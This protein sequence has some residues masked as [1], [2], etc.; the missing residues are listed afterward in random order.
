MHH[1]LGF[2]V[3][4]ACL[5]A[6]MG[7]SQPRSSD[8]TGAKTGTVTTPPPPVAAGHSHPSEGPHHGDLI[9]LGNEEFHAEMVH[10]E[11]SVTIYLLDAAAKVAVPIEASDLVINL[12]H[13]GNPEQF[14]LSASPDT[15]D[16]TGKSSR[17]VSTDA[18]LASHMEGE[19]AGGTLRV[20]INGKPY[21]G[22]IKHDHD[23][24]HDH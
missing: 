4:I 21:R 1:R 6:L 7:C 3:A 18:E 15:G 11:K 8:S 12:T 16:P 22:E 20:T 5:A 9:E 10:D 23:H 19:W 13:D 14:T 17:F 24:D 2:V